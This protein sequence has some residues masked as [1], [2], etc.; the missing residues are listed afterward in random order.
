MKLLFLT[1]C[2]TLTLFV[3]CTK[4]ELP[5]KN[6][7]EVEAAMPVT[8]VSAPLASQTLSEEIAQAKLLGGN[9]KFIGSLEKEVLKLLLLENSPEVNQFEVLSYGFDKFNG[10]KTGFLAGFGCQKIAVR[11][12]TKKF[13][14][15]SECTKPAKKLAEISEDLTNKN[16]ITVIFLTS[17]WKVI[18]GNAA[19]IN[20]DRVCQILIKDNKV[21][22]FECQDTVF[23][24]R[25]SGIDINLYELKIKKYS[26]NRNQAD[27]L[28]I[29]GGQYKDMLENK[30]IKMTVPMTGK[31]SII[32]KE[33]KVKDDF[34]DMQNKLLGLEEKKQ[35]EVKD[36][37]KEEAP[38]EEKAH[39][40]EPEYIG[41]N[42]EG[43]KEVSGTTGAKTN[44]EIIEEAAGE[45]QN[46]NGEEGEQPPPPE[47]GEQPAAPNSVPPSGPNPNQPYGR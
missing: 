34:T 24:P 7:E 15:F 11:A 23:S 46:Q 12:G 28:V 44:E 35:E 29:E 14:V 31:I 43:F 4:K 45:N 42:E 41:E 1:T 32:E 6:S 3:S 13:E 40:A 27:E 5:A 17:N 21:Q 26:F 39:T 33:I 38:K 25:M 30:K 10:A 9:I 36:G 47:A 22:T 8:T 16:K 37:K 20:P 2:I 19:G 18:L